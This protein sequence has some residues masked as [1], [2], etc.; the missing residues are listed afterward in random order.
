MSVSKWDEGSLEETTVL[1]FFDASPDEYSK[2]DFSD[3]SPEL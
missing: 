3:G 1:V 2:R